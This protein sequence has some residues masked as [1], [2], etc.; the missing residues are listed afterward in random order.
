[1]LG[2]KL[3]R[4][5]CGTSKYRTRL[6]DHEVDGA[7]SP[8]PASRACEPQ[9]R[10]PVT[11]MAFSQLPK[12]ARNDLQRPAV[13]VELESGIQLLVSNSNR[14]YL[15]LLAPSIGER[16]TIGR[17]G[18]RGIGYI[19]AGQR[20][21]LLEKL[22][23]GRRVLSCLEDRGGRERSAL[24]G[25]ESIQ[26]V[27]IRALLANPFRHRGRERSGDRTSQDRSLRVFTN[28][29]GDEGRPGGAGL[30]LEQDH[31]STGVL[32]NDV[33]KNERNDLRLGSHGDHDDCY[34]AP[35]QTPA[36]PGA[37][38]SRCSSDAPGALCKAAHAGSIPAVA[39]CAVLVL[40][41]GRR[42]TGQLRDRFR[43][44]H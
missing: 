29:L 31:S 7:P 21:E 32:E 9:S 41:D 22:M 30:E 39:T 26:D 35:R 3:S 8:E 19:G 12:H 20:R 36:A 28:E 24:L 5:T 34:R 15:A 4:F 16:C 18:A 10:L 6:L 27:T 40:S 25:R 33:L 23:A 44:T 14:E 13:V 38:V 42:V 1:M 17:P 11:Q 43:A 2:D 37:V